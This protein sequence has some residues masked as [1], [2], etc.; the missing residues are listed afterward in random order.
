MTVGGVAL[1]LIGSWMLSLLIAS[2]LYGVT[3][4][5]PRTAITVSM[6]LIVVS[7]VASI[8]PALIAMRVCLM[9]SLLTE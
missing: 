6:V 1:G 2:Q 7:L 8:V 5:N 4:S 9:E 3:A